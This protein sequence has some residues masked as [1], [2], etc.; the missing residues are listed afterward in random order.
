MI[1]LHTSH[2]NTMI[3]PACDGWTERE[4]NG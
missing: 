2:F 3:V 1:Q 4:T